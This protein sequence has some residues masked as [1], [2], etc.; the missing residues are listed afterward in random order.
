MVLPI[1]TKTVLLRLLLG[2]RLE[3]LHDILRI[4]GDLTRN[5]SS[6]KLKG[7]ETAVR[8]HG[9]RLKWPP[10]G[11]HIYALNEYHLKNEIGNGISVSNNISISL[12]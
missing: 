9:I 5:R 1:E 6:S 11:T 10:L 7:A 4:L 8:R 2:L 12:K 3:I